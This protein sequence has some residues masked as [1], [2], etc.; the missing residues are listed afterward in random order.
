VPAANVT[1]TPLVV[2][3]VL[4]KFWTFRYGDNAA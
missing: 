3:F 1:S 4:K 2:H